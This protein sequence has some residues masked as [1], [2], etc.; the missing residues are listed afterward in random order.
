MGMTFANLHIDGK[1]SLERDVLING[2]K[3]FA[4]AAVLALI[5]AFTT[6]SMSHAFET[7]TLLNK[8]L[9]SLSEVE[10]SDQ[11]LEV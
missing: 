9:T 2:E 1:T 10:I 8:S 11:I 3:G 7:S 6:R 4:I 5:N